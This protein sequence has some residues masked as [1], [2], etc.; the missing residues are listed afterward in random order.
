[1]NTNIAKLSQRTSAGLAAIAAGILLLKAVGVDMP[2]VPPSL[3]MVVVAAI[4][5]LA[6]P[7]RVTFVVALVAAAFEAIGL[8]AS[9]SLGGLFGPTS[10]ANFAGNLL[11]V[12]GVAVT[13]L[14]A[15]RG[16]RASGRPPAGPTA[17]DGPQAQ[18]KPTP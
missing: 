8:A 13:L 14:V 9:G 15:A 3:V 10:V 1:M 17:A 5:V 7:S 2:L 6:R 16:I 11:R 12:L 18:A 4:A